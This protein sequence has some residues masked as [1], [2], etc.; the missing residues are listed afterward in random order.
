[1]EVYQRFKDFVQVW[2][3]HHFLEKIIHVNIAVVCSSEQ[4]ELLF[5]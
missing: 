4:T 3:L 1:M 2:D 5:D